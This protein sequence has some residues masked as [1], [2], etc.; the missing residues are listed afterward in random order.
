[1]KWGYLDING[2]IY[3]DQSVYAGEWG[4]VSLKTVQDAL[5]LLA[6]DIEG[7]K[8]KINTPGGVVDE[9]F[10]I[11]NEIDA[12]VKS[13][14]LKYVSLASGSVASA[15]VML[16]ASAPVREVYKT[17]QA[18][19]HNPQIDPWSLAFETS[20]LEAKDL[21]ELAKWL[22]QEETR[23]V[24]YT[25][26]KTGC[27]PEQLR[28]MMNSD[29][30]LTADQMLEMKLATVILDEQKEQS[31]NLFRHL[32]MNY[33]KTHSQNSNDMATEAKKK[34]AATAEADKLAKATKDLKAAAAAAGVKATNESTAKTSDGKELTFSS[35]TPTVGDTVTL[36]G[37]AAPDGT[38]TMENGDSIVVKD[39]KVESITPA[40]TDDTTDDVKTE[41]EKKLEIEI[42]NLKAANKAIEEQMATM[43]AAVTTATATVEALTKNLKDSRSGFVAPGRGTTNSLSGEKARN[44]EENRATSMLERAAENRKKAAET[45]DAADK[46]K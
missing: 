18:F 27:D 9:A 21:E 43:T 8:L 15:G 42:A 20:S 28:T 41:N 31:T 35:D 7:V 24:D 11:I 16:F 5:K 25:A 46:K 2:I 14:N 1:M 29:S 4:I 23:I 17:S 30:Y 12:F 6:S 10:A 37:S 40:S 13:R 22:R 38:Y 44:T 19:V 33:K 34:T 36:D 3:P 39:G 26:G 45:Q 32:V